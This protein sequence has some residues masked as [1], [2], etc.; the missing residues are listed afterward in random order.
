MLSWP[1][2]CSQIH[3]MVGQHGCGHMGRQKVIDELLSRVDFGHQRGKSN[4]PKAERDDDCKREEGGGYTAPVVGV[5]CDGQSRLRL[6]S[7]ENGYG[8]ETVMQRLG[9]NLSR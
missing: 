9:R 5:T 6:W 8:Q 1:L 2:V 3:A 4:A 7:N